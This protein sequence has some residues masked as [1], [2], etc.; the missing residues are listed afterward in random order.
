MEAEQPVDAEA[1]ADKD[2][3][4]AA[5]RMKSAVEVVALEMPVEWV[6]PLEEEQWGISVR[7]AFV[8]EVEEVVSHLPAGTAPPSQT[9][10]WRL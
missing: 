3:G 9:M 10:V 2:V 8:E 6:E 7:R 4:P 5:T 1:A